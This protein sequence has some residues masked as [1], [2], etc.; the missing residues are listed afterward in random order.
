MLLTTHAQGEQY[1]SFSSQEFV[2]GVA[3]HHS[4][5]PTKCCECPSLLLDTVYLDCSSLNCPSDWLL[6]FFLMFVIY[7]FIWPCR[8]ACGILVPWPG[9]EPV[10][11]AVK[12]QSP[13][14]WTA[15][16]FLIDCF[17]QAPFTFLIW[18]FFQMLPL[19]A[20]LFHLLTSQKHMIPIPTPNQV[21]CCTAYWSRASVLSP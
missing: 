9:I 4:V 11:S 3:F 12:A 16:E 15:R 13:N 19:F 2:S 20:T 18:P 7:L 21:F 10:P 8:R 17:L 14:H 1:P 6:F 5:P